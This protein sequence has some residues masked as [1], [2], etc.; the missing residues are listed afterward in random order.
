MTEIFF[1]DFRNFK[2]LFPNYFTESRKI[3]EFI[4]ND[5]E[6]TQKNDTGLCEDIQN[7]I[8][9]DRPSFPNFQANKYAELTVTSSPKFKFG[10][11]S[12][13]I[14]LISTIMA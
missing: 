1:A 6:T 2:A 13:L 10:Q 12:Q 5:V 9:V 8:I 7:T 3:E 11:R 14:L 4:E